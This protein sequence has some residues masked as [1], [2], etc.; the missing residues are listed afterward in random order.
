[1]STKQP[2]G[3]GKPPEDGSDPADLDA[4]AV[5]DPEA[6]EAMIRK[7]LNV[8][9]ES[10]D[11][12][13]IEF[14]KLMGDDTITRAVASRWKKLR[15]SEAM[16]ERPDPWPIVERN[17]PRIAA[18][19]RANWGKRALDDY[20]AGLVID[21]R[22]SRQGFPVEVLA[23]VMEIARLHADQ[24]NL[25]KPILPWEADVSETKWWYKR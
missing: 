8:H 20:F 24:F 14:P 16:K 18:H 25:E 11:D 3:S 6:G 22:G 12:T 2:P 10:A 5:F 15:E 21:E 13:E 4:F 9:G 17:F 19:I 1:M 23:A 7:R